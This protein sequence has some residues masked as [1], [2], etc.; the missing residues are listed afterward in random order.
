M[1]P[2][3]ATSN[4]D[5]AFVICVLVAAVL[6]MALEILTFD[7]VGLLII[8]VLMFGGILEPGQAL[9]GLSNPALVTVGAMF[10][11]SAGFTKTGAINFIGLRLTKLAARGEASL[12]LAIMAVVI[13]LSAFV[14]NTPVVVV[15]LPIVILVCDRAGKQASKFLIPLSYASIFGGACTL[16]GTSTNLLIAERLRELGDRQLGLFDMTPLGLILVG[17]GVL[18]LVLV[19]RHLLP[20]RATVSGIAGSAGLR[21][22]LTEVQILEKSK[23]VGKK[24][25]E[26]TAKDSANLKIL[27]LIRGDTILYPDPDETLEDHDLLLVAGNVN[28]IYDLHQQDGVEILPELRRKESEEKAEEEKS[29]ERVRGVEMTLAEVVLTPTSRLLGRTINEISFRARYGVVVFAIL[30]RGSHL[31][32]KIGDAPLRMGDTLLVQGTPEAIENLRAAEAFILVEGVARRVVRRRKAPWAIVIGSAVVVALTAELAPIVVV[33]LGGATLMVLTRCVTL[34]EAYEAMDWT[35]L[36]LIA[37]TL[38]L[39][40]AMMQTE[41]LTMIVDGFFSGVRSISHEPVLLISA[42]YLMTAVLTEL[43]SNNATAIL[44]TPAALEVASRVSVDLG[45][46]VDPLPFVMAVLFAASASFSTPIGYQTNTFVYGPGGYKFS[47]YFRVGLPLALL[48]W[49]VASIGIPIIW[50]I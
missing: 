16:I 19:G 10:V 29:G 27:Q 22:Y 33:A 6:L 40:Q 44:M 1:L 9:A 26:L 38:A 2:L 39:G 12:L 21:E 30:R 18:Y 7:L 23:W 5:I 17:T 20:S 48:F 13:P 15:M 28:A 50:P 47:D 34:K 32:E 43:V 37:G 46:P 31:R 8:V 24:L 4:F 25:G 35:V 42:L 11:I 41:A 45:R 14:N 3:A 36:F 49:I